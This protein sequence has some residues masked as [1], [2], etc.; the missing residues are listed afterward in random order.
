MTT[1][2]M[3]DMFSCLDA[4]SVKFLMDSHVAPDSGWICTPE[5]TQTY[6]MCEF[7]FVNSTDDLVLT[8]SKTVVYS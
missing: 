3:P 7:R 6:E 5:G 8:D 1:D 4:A 2:L